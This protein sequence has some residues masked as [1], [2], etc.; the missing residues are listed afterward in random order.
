[1]TEHDS[2]TGVEA[3]VHLEPL[4]GRNPV[5][6]LFRNEHG[7]HMAVSRRVGIGE[8]LQHLGRACH[9]VAWFLVGNWDDLAVSK[10][11]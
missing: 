1:M 10:R 5:L 9:T 11:F 3:R 4:V 2:S 6:R 7:E 8:P